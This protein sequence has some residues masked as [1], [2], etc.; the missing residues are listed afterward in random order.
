MSALDAGA[1]EVIENTSERRFEGYIDRTLVG[2]S[3]YEIVD[4]VIVFPHSYTL[5]EFRGR[6]IGAV[7]V[8]GA[9]DAVVAAGG[10]RVHATCP[11]VRDWIDRH[12]DYE[13]LTRPSA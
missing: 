4:D 7:V 2:Y 3:D 8:Q 11:F 9:M 13:H 5:P 6:G 10:L 1:V 12:P